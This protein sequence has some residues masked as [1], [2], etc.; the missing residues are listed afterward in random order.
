MYL[1]D[2][3]QGTKP[4]ARLLGHQKAINHVTFS[5]DG[6]LIASAGWDNHTKIWSARFV[7]SM[8]PEA[9]TIANMMTNTE[10]ANLSTRSEAT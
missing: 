3:S 7:F 4:V 6:S 5:P 1:W 2:P 10:M 9:V 8:T